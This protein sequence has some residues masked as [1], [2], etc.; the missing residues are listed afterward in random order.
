[1]ARDREPY[2]IGKRSV[3][4]SLRRSIVMALKWP[5][6]GQTWEFG[7][8]WKQGTLYPDYDAHVLSL[9]SSS[10]SSFLVKLS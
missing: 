1:M 5:F 10:I 7:F 8:K 4:Q 6:P 2:A 3:L 9:F